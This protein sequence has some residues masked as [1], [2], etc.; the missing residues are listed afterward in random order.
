[1]LVVF[2]LT[3]AFIEESDALDTHHFNQKYQVTAHFVHPVAH[4][5][6]G[7]VFLEVVDCVFVQSFPPVDI[8]STQE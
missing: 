7:E 1:M 2:H 6:D 3:L 8:G 5:V 4:L